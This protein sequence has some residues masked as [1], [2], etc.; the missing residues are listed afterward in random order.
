VSR[1]ADQVQDPRPEENIN[2]FHNENEEGAANARRHGSHSINI[3]V[4][5]VLETV[6][7]KTDDRKNEIKQ[8]GAA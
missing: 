5:H 8:S 4:A 1:S 3:T 6:D 2:E 7:D